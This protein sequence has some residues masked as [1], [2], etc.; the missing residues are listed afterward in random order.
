MINFK[1]L[2]CIVVSVLV[3]GCQSNTTNSSPSIDESSINEV[4]SSSE[5]TSSSEIEKEKISVILLAGQSN[6]VGTTS[7][8]YLVDDENYDE[9]RMGYSDILI[10]YGGICRFRPVK[11]TIG[12]QNPSMFG[13]EI[14]MASELSYNFYNDKVVFIK[15]AVGGTR[16]NPAD[17]NV[18]WTPPIDG[19]KPGGLYTIFTNFVHKALEKLS[20][21]YEVSLDAMC[22][23]QGESDCDTVAMANK[24]EYYLENFVSSLREEFKE[25]NSNFAFIDAY[26]SQFWG[27]G[28]LYKIVNKAKYNLSLKDN[29]HYIIDTIENGLTYNKEPLL[30]PDFFHYD[31]QSEIL[32]GRLF[33]R[34]YMEL[35]PLS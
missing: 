33:A 5:E 2:I 21:K 34:K 35:F 26:I 10:A 12:G 3:C 31:S 6:M 7:W 23:M 4:S 32:L 30:S 28:S 13:P 20:T 15:Y 17:I 27:S 22:W 24:Y 11:L 9:Y 14:G 19:N 8:E 25:Y 16:I 18:S 1:Y 29:N